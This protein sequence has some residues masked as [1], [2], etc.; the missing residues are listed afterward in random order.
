MAAILS[1]RV[2]ESAT[3]RILVEQTCSSSST[4]LQAQSQKPAPF[5]AQASEPDGSSAWSAGQDNTGA[6]LPV[7]SSEPARVLGSTGRT[8]SPGR[9]SLL[10]VDAWLRAAD[11]RGLRRFPKLGNS[12][13]GA[14]GCV[15]KSSGAT[16][17]R[18]ELG[19]TGAGLCDIASHGVGCRRN[20]NR[21][22]RLTSAVHCRS[23]DPSVAR[24]CVPLGH[25]SKH[26]PV[27]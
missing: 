14:P 9:L 15:R 2:T 5:R 18:C 3:C 21:M 11:F 27:Q 26:H 1:A 20:I 22:S 17:A 7:A 13:R 19:A 12:D 16:G 25:Q 24:A 4:A 8:H 23:D 10:H 6:V